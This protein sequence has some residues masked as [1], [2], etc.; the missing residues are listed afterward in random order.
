MI[1]TVFEVLFAAAL[2]VGVWRRERLIAFE[3]KIADAFDLA[4]RSLLGR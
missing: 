4:F 1:A 2:L 3:R